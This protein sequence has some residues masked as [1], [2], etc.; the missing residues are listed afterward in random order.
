MNFSPL[1]DLQRFSRYFQFLLPMDSA[2]FCK[3]KSLDDLL[4]RVIMPS[5]D[6]DDK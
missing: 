4:L 6:V 5:A 1:G 3:L 2:L